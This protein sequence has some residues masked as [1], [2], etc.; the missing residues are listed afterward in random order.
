MVVIKA[1]PPSPLDKLIDIEC[2]DD[3]DE[4]VLHLINTVEEEL[5]GLNLPTKGYGVGYLPFV[6]SRSRRDDIPNTEH[7]W[8]G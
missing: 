2:T 5:A 7:N 3:T 4:N 1:T 8:Q 6:F